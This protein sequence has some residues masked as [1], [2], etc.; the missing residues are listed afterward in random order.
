[1]QRRP[2]HRRII[3]AGILL[4]FAGVLLSGCATYRPAN[5]EEAARLAA[6][7]KIGDVITCETRHG[8][9]RSFTVKAIE[10]GWLIGE[11]SEH[12]YVD[13]V[14]Q[15]KIWRHALGDSALRIASTVAT[16]GALG[17]ATQGLSPAEG[18]IPGQ[19][20]RGIS[21]SP[22]PSADHPG[23]LTPALKVGE[24]IT[25][26][27]RYGGTKT[28]KITAI[29]HGWLIGG[30]ERV[31]IDDIKRVETHRPA[32]A[33]GVLAAGILIATAIVLYNTPIAAF[34]AL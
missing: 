16:L 17:Y 23:Q 22:S 28:F 21:A 15:V 11:S 31:F 1:M 6:S 27:L 2:L 33:D 20:W 7:I 9:S 5:T 24:T 10:G 18:E 4:L 34:A 29:E 30:S 13:D 14:T 3:A 12:V 25:C 32:I 8:P 26:D 19:I